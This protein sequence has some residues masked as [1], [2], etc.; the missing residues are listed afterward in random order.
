VKNGKPALIQNAVTILLI[1]E[2]TMCVHQIAFDMRRNSGH[3]ISRSAIVRALICAALPHFEEW[4]TVNPKR[5]SATHSWDGSL[6][7]SNDARLPHPA[8]SPR[9]V[10]ILKRICTA[11]T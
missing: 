4:C 6:S 2:Q 9:S 11:A 5:S 3:P 10:Q 7:G 8:T 1:N